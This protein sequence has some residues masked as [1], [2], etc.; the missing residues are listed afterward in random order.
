MELVELVALVRSL[1]A[2]PAGAAE[3]RLLEA[4]LLE[5]DVS[6]L[7]LEAKLERIPAEKGWVGVELADERHGHASLFL[8]PAG[9]GIPLHDHPGLTVL[10]RPVIGRVRVEAWDWLEP[11]PAPGES[12]RARQ[13]LDAVLDPTSLALWTLPDEGNVHGLAPVGGPAAFV[14]LFAPYYDD[15]RRCSYY[16]VVAPDRLRRRPAGSEEP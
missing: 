15:E 1:L 2:R 6:A 9:G 8:L 4:A 11:P 14:D 10:L 12:A 13:A 5:L 7:D 3:L 16:D